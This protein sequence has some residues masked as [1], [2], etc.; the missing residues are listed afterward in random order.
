MYRT[1]SNE[2]APETTT[3]TGKAIQIESIPEDI[4]LEADDNQVASV[5]N[6]ETIKI[7]GDGTNI[8]TAATVTESG[9]MDTISVS[10]KPDIQVDSVTIN[11]GG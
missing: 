2:V 10:L 7:A 8:S 9:S 6:G 3:D 5:V 4:K 1:E 11:N